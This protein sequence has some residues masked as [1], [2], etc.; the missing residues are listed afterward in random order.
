MSIGAFSHR[1]T[2]F[3]AKPVRLAISPKYER[4]HPFPK[5]IYTPRLRHFKK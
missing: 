1:L 3:R 2:V 5:F 4:S